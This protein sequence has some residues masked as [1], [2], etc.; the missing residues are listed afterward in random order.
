MKRQG[1]IFF[2]PDGSGEKTTFS[3]AFPEIESI[4]AEV[5]ESGLGNAGLGV[6]RFNRNSYREFV[7]CS[8]TSCSGHGAPTGDILRAMV[9]ARQ[10][11]YRQPLVCEG[12]E[13]S[14]NP[15]ANVFAIEITLTY[16]AL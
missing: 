13:E 12:R 7:N 10:T 9:K 6:R 15:C 4:A 16:R 14:G 11:T 8:N 1:D 2:R 3:E 5:T